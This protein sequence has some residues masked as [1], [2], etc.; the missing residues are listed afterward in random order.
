MIVVATPTGQIGSQV[1]EK[2]LVAKEGVR[3]IARDPARLAERVR[4]AVEIV[5][6]ESD[7]EGVLMRAL[8][9]VESLFLVVPP[10]FT[11]SNTREYCL[12]FTRPVCRA[13]ESKGV[14]RVVTVSGVGRGD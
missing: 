5:Q 2:L 8:Q 14:K 10:S 4:T 7:D 9:G 13:I 1:I 3:V 6:G 11:T 12:Q